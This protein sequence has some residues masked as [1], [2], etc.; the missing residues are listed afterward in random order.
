MSG[1]FNVQV[2]DTST[3][4]MS[5]VNQ[6]N[7]PEII[8]MKNIPGEITFFPSYIFHYTT[9]HY[10]FNPRITIAMDIHVSDFISSS[11]RVDL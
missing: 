6:L 1:H 3:C 10:S 5:P 2:K 9:P 7:D 4:Y 11:T 8:E